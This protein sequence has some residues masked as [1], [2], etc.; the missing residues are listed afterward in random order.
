M[1]GTAVVRVA[2]VVWV[3]VAVGWTVCGGVRD[4][5]AAGVFCGVVVLGEALRVPPGADREGA[6]L[7]TAGALGYALLGP[8]G[9]GV[10]QAVAVACAGAAL[11]TLLRPHL[12]AVPVA[13]PAPPPVPVPAPAHRRHARPAAR[14]EARWGPAVRRG[15]G[16]GFAALCC[17]PLHGET[18]LTGAALAAVSVG[19][20]ALVG[21]CDAA[22]AAALGPRPFA[23]GVGDELRGLAGMGSA[24]CAGGVVL[25]LAVGSA[26]LWAVPVVALPLLLTQLGLRGHAAVRATYRQTVTALARATEVAGYTPVGHARRVGEL[27]TAVG[28]E[29]GLPARR[30][31]LLEYAALMHDIGQLS[32]V[33]PVPRGATEPLDAGRREAIAVRGGEVVRRTGAPAEVALIVEVQARPYRDQPLAGRIVRAVNDFEDLTGENAAPQRRLAAVER[34][35]LDTD[36]TYDPQVVDAL[37]RV[38]AH[39]PTWAW[40][41]ARGDGKELG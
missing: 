21:L 16:V 40:L 7:A 20:L 32:L 19:V 5:A 27:A 10:P 22:V 8:G 33:D 4:P 24:V 18:R 34:M 36:H 9:A 17:Q 26:G 28:R 37:T 29:L 39:R 12:P 23:A 14:G 2:G 11:G 15:A 25:A 3:T 35:R 38:L 31:M 13:V 1:N 30:L 41:D 6:P